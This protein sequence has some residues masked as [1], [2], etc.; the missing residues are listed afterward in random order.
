MEDTRTRLGS[1]CLFA[2]LH[3]PNREFPAS[4]YGPPGP[5][6]NLPGPEPSPS[7]PSPDDS[8]KAKHLHRSCPDQHCARRGRADMWRPYVLLRNERNWIDEAPI[9]KL[10]GSIL[11]PGFFNKMLHCQTHD[12]SIGIN[13][14]IDRKW[15]PLPKRDAIFPEDQDLPEVL[16]MTDLRDLPN[17]G[18]WQI[19]QKMI[20]CRKD[21]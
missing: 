15:R 13:T 14:S 17:N 6:T 3:T 16:K 21:S 9:R 19:G 18:H 12:A 20:E 11:P 7:F 10:Q 4:A 2:S 8:P 5:T 1:T